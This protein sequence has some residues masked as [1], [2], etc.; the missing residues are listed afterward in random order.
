M[1][2]KIGDRREIA[3]RSPPQ[4][5]R[6]NSRISAAAAGRVQCRSGPLAALA[7]RAGGRSRRDR[8]RWRPLPMVVFGTPNRPPIY[9]AQAAIYRAPHAGAGR[10]LSRL[11]LLLLL[12]KKKENLRKKSW[13]ICYYTPHPHIYYVPNTHPHHPIYILHPY[14]THPHPQPSNQKYR[15]LLLLL[16]YIYCTAP[17]IHGAGV[18]YMYIVVYI[19]YTTTAPTTTTTTTK[20]VYAPTTTTKIV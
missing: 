3:L 18:L 1:R 4:S 13:Y 5:P 6:K 15:D 14:Y 11:L 9:R 10:A 17:H 8:S 12:Q 16:Q 20:I 7:V 2:P 19:L